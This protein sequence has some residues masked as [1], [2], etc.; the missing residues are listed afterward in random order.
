MYFATIDCSTGHLVRLGMRPLQIHNFRLQHPSSSD[1]A[2]LRETLD[3]Q[4]RRFDSHIV[5]S[6]DTWMLEWCGSRSSPE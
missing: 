3:R 1:R 5:L 6:E 2:W 4:C